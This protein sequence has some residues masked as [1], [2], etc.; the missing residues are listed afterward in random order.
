MACE[1]WGLPDSLART[2][3]HHHDPYR[4][5]TAGH[6]EALVSTIHFADLAMFPSAMPGTPGFADAPRSTIEESLMPKVPKGIS[7]SV[8]DLHQL[9]VKTATDVDARCV[10]LGIA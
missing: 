2:V 5:A 8:D 6:V 3:L 10:A 4:D 7:I 1:Q 9:I